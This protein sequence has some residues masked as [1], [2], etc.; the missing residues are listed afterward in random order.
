VWPLLPAA[1]DG[2]SVS[3]YEAVFLPMAPGDASSDRPLRRD[4]QEA[5]LTYCDWAPVGPRRTEA[6]QPSPS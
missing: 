2:L 5:A 6:M 3:P 4:A 1:Q